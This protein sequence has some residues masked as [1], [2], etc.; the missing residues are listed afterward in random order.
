MWSETT[1]GIQLS[2]RKK[3][4]LVPNWCHTFL[5]HKFFFKYISKT[6]AVIPLVFSYCCKKANVLKM[7]VKKNAYFS[8]KFMSLSFS[9][10][11]HMKLS[12]GL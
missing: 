8:D 12:Y 11:E 5:H 4:V 9:Q 1:S 6:I 2:Y 7:L 10:T 3:W